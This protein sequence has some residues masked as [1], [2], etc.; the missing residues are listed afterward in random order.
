MRIRIHDIAAATRCK[1]LDVAETERSAT[2]LVS[3]ELRDCRLGRV[4]TVEAYDSGTPRSAA[5]L[6]LDL[7]LLNL[8]YRRKQFDQVLIASRPW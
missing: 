4:D 3:L 2:V 8:S 5:I 7:G 1:V 6:V